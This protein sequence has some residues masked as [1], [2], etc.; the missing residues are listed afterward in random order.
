[1][2]DGDDN[3][4]SSN[5]ELVP[6]DH[7]V[8]PLNSRPISTSSSNH[9]AHDKVM[10]D[11]VTD[12]RKSFT[13]IYQRNHRRAQ[14]SKASPKNTPSASKFTLPEGWSVKKVLRRSG[15][16]ADKYYREPGTGRQFRSLKEVE[17][18]VNGEFP[19]PLRS[20]VKRLTYHHDE[21]VERDITVEVTPRP[22]RVKRL[23]HHH[24]E[25]NSGKDLIVAGGKILDMEE[26]KDNQ[27][28]LANV[29]P[30]SVV[31][32][33]AYNLPDG[34]VVEEVPRRSGSYADKYY[35]E[36]GGQKFR[37]MLAAQK[38]LA[39]VEENSPLSVVLE[40]IKEKS[41]PLSKA[42]KI[43]S[44]MKKRGSY[45]SPKESISKKEK[46]SSSSSSFGSP[47]S[48]IN[49]VIGGNGGDAWNAFA[50]EALVPDS[51]KQHWGNTFMMAINNTKHTAPVS[52]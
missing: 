5:R 4:V 41:L 10:E 14:N 11:T 31:P 27:Y 16:P 19:P 17:R 32:G 3:Y 24:D 42:F 6:V 22:T 48:K 1:M 47:P 36:P 44:P 26:D 8:K 43:N 29:S 50:D 51:V 28:Q 52:A 46:T 45:N 21:K 34:W 13:H 40:E 7:V 2:A 9:A 20:S 18:Y 12:R 30:T 49:W 23:K 38:Y 33:S 39:E 35:Y 15:G 25:K 37:S